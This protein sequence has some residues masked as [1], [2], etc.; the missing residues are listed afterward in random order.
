M[1]SSL[2]L[3]TA[4]L[5][6]LLMPACSA[7]ESP[8][9][10]PTPSPSASAAP[11]REVAQ[12]QASR[13]A[14]RAQSQIRLRAARQR[15]GL[16]LLPPIVQKGAR[17]QSARRASVVGSAR[18]RPARPGRRVVIQRRAGGAWRKHVTTRQSRRGTVRFTG[19]AVNGRGR[20]YAYRA[21]A[22][23]HRGVARKSTRAVRT[24]SWRLHFSDEFSG[25]SLNRRKWDYRALGVRE[26]LSGRSTAESARQSVGVG[27]G[28]LRLSVRRMPGER[29]VFRN[30]HIG[31]QGKYAFRYGIAAARIKFPRGQG[32][33]GSFWMQPTA[34][35][36]VPGRPARSGAEIDVAE[37]FGAGYRGGGLAHFVWWLGKGGEMIKHGDVRP[38]ATAMLRR[39]DAWWKN[40][41]VFSVEW[42]PRRYVFRVDGRE[43]W[44]TNRGVSRVQEFLIL[45]LLTS[46]WELPK[47]N[48]S[49]LPTTMNV[50]WVRVW[51]P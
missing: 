36:D 46:E 7:V 16:A 34:G 9:A 31:T 22:M 14:Q 33:H 21:V 45:S 48:L 38:Q 1:K 10:G 40:Y 29:G 2:R 42:T 32:Q 26:R 37:F 25:R 51:K 43:T 28:T 12:P 39:R 3:A 6:V 4:S 19:A 35:H 17:P 20:S 50:D 41:H 13:S 30:G 5:A 27:N 18:F 15:A 44:R 24:N 49:S 8:T 11:S 47:L 23:R